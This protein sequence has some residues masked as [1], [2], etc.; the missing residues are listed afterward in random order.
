MLSEK[1]RLPN[2]IPPTKKITTV[3][4]N[5]CFKSHILIHNIL[6]AW[7]K[8]YKTCKFQ[9]TCMYHLVQC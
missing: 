1:K 7:L 2:L 4:F 6:A 9:P 8:F 3:L 5:F